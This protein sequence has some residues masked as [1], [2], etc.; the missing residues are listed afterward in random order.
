MLNGADTSEGNDEDAASAVPRTVVAQIEAT[1]PELPESAVLDD[2]TVLS[3]SA[4]PFQQ[5]LSTS[6]GSDSVCDSRD[7]EMAAD[8]RDQALLRRRLLEIQSD[9]SCPDREKARRMQALL[10][11][12]YLN[13]RER[14]PSSESRA[15]DSALSEVDLATTFHN[16]VTGVMG[17]AHYQRNCKLQCSTCSMWAT[18]RFCHNEHDG[19]DHEL[20]RQETKNMLCMFCKTVQPAQQHC[21]HCNK[22]MASYFCAKCKL[23]DNDPAKNIYHCNSCGICRVGLGLGKDFFHCDRCNGRFPRALYL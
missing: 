2:V 19:I 23:W 10:A 17:C 12:K 15:R 5:G 22:R 18:C 8:V 7:G 3:P 11:S 14:R 4:V 9:S 13:V 1:G 20:V 16:E 6:A 21:R